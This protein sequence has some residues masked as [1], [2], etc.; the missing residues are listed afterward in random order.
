[1]DAVDNRLETVRQWLLARKPE[2]TD[3]DLDLDLI[4]NR[5]VDSLAF[6]EFV[7]FLEE[8]VGRELQTTAETVQAFRTL[9]SIEAEILRGT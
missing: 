2:L 8:L 6:T 1:M 9:R 7:F 3:I 4:E 5:I